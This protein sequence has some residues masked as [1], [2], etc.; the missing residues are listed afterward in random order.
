[1]LNALVKQQEFIQR[2][3]YLPRIGGISDAQWLDTWYT[4]D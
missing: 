4:I 1:M 2:A 3:K